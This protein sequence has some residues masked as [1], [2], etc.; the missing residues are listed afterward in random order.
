[1]FPIFI[2]FV[3]LFFLEVSHSS[4]NTGYTATSAAVSWNTTHNFNA[5]SYPKS[6]R[7]IYDKHANSGAGTELPDATYSI[8]PDANRNIITV[9]HGLQWLLEVSQILH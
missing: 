9:R 5:Y 3:I 1:M 2:C 4:F 6:C 7:E 8:K